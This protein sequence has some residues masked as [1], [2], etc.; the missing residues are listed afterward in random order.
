MRAFFLLFIM[1]CI[2]LVLFYSLTHGYY[3][4]E[5]RNYNAVNNGEI[6]HYLN[7]LLRFDLLIVFF[8]TLLLF[9]SCRS[10]SKVKSVNSVVKLCVLFIFYSVNIINS[11]AFAVNNYIRNYRDISELN[12]FPELLEKYGVIVNLVYIAPLILSVVIFFVFLLFI[13]RRMNQFS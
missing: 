5:L 11:L 7:A 10:F 8:N 13:K 6:A 2:S 4:G 1:L 9:F 12:V 3:R